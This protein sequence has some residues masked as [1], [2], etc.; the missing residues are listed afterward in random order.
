M[1]SKKSMAVHIEIFLWHNNQWKMYFKNI[2]KKYY[3]QFN[4][5]QSSS[6]REVCLYMVNL[7]FLR[8]LSWYLLHYIVEPPLKETLSI[9]EK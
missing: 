6:D 2:K 5:G 4:V 9:Y 8:A 3:V 1:I 7:Q